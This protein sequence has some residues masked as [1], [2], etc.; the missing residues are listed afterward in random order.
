MKIKDLEGHKVRVGKTSIT[1]VDE[2]GKTCGVVCRIKN[3]NSVQKNMLS[4]F[5]HVLKSAGIWGSKI[6]GISDSVFTDGKQ[7]YYLNNLTPIEFYEEHLSSHT[8]FNNDRK[9]YEQRL[10]IAK[11]AAQYMTV[12]NCYII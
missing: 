4:D 6:D 5:Y 12:I 1:C 7:Y 10:V 2:Y 9:R 11:N 3:I 8:G